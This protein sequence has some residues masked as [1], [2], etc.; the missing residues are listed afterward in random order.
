MNSGILL[1][2]ITAIG[3]GTWPLIGRASGANQAWVTTLLMVI[4][5]IVIALAQANKLMTEPLT[6]KM[7]AL[8][9]FAGLM[10]G[11]SMIAYG[12]LL[13]EGRFSLSIVI[14][15]ILLLVT[16]ITVV[17]GTIFF[18]EHLTTSKTIGILLACVA[19]WLLSR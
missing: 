16:V 11:I 14:P 15:T 12:Q 19:T 3:F 9:T 6:G 2:L 5:T 13:M 17:G 18:G 8:M 7:L 1:I 10:N 4:S